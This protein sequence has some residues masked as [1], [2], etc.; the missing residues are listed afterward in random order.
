MKFLMQW[1]ESVLYP[2]GYQIW[3][4]LV[5]LGIVAVLSH[6]HEVWLTSRLHDW[7]TSQS[8]LIRLGIYGVCCLVV[9]IVVSIMAF[10]V[11]DKLKNN[12]S[13]E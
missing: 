1:I 9:F 6:W 4:V 5:S 8:L 7:L 3:A 10:Y 11:V 13:P 12:A 2:E